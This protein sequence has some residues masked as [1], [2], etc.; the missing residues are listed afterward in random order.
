MNTLS[1]FNK[2]N[3][4]GPQMRSFLFSILLVL[5]Y[6]HGFSQNKD[7]QTNAHTTYTNRMVLKSGWDEIEEMILQILKQVQNNFY[8][9]FL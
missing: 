5:F 3:I 7:T 4:L 9:C 8:L 2:F 1:G 6:L